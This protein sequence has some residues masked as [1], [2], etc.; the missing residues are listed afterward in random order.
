MVVSILPIYEQL[1]TA[2]NVQHFSM[3]ADCHFSVVNGA[4]LAMS[5][6]PSSVTAGSFIAI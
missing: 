2:A 3:L 4:D 5:N 1:A 6:G